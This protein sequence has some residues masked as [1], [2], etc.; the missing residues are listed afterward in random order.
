M[1][2]SQRKFLLL[3]YVN[4]LS[5]DLCSKVRLFTDDTSPL[6]VAH[7]INTSANELNN[8]L[9]KVSNWAFQRKM[10]FNSNPSKQTQKV[11]FSQN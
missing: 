11:I 6:N 5:G 7:D 4:D 10:S 8:D 3:I 9:K 2:K 1:G